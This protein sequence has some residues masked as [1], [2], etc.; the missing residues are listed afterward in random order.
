[1]QVFFTDLN[2]LGGK[3]RKSQIFSSERPHRQLAEHIDWQP[4]GQ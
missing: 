2:A 4:V 1:M 3:R